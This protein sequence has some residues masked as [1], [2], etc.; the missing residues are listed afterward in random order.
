MNSKSCYSYI[1]LDINS[2]FDIEIRLIFAD[3]G[4]WLSLD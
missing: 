3:N 1:K 2:Q 4:N